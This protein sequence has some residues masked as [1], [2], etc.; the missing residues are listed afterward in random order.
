MNKASSW[1]ASMEK[2]V[3]A[4]NGETV[5]EGSKRSTS[6][7]NNEWNKDKWEIVNQLVTSNILQID[8]NS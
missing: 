8:G 5:G 2:S 4:L 3:G 6:L 1:A 7:V